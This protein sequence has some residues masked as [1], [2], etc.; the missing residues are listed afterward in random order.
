MKTRAS[1]FQLAWSV[2]LLALVSLASGCRTSVSVQPTSSRTPSTPP[3]DAALNFAHAPPAGR[4]GLATGWGERRE[5]PVTMVQFVR[6][7]RSRPAATGH[8][9]YNDR[10]GLDAV[11]ARTGA[12]P[13]PS[14]GLEPLPR[15]FVSAGLQSGS[16]EWLP[17]SHV[18]GSRY[19]L[20]ELGQPYAIVVRNDTPGRL[21]VVA[22]VDGLDVLDGKPASLRKPGYVLAAGQTYAI[23][24]F[25]TGTDAVATFRFSDV[26]GS[27][28]ARRHDDPRNVGVIGLAVFPEK[29]A[30]VDRRRQAEPFP[31]SWSTPP[32]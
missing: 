22:S 7:D 27:Y 9:Y 19:F 30:E 25:R 23:E 10:A 32:R 8:L 3:S 24:G 12:Q 2:V 26:H 29:D 4:P 15:G 31:G 28:A 5:A 13:Q 1:R 6:A 14:L 16:A 21:E 17:A 20:G 11:L 18:Q